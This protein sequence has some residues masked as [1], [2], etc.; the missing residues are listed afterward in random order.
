MGGNVCLCVST[1]TS[2]CMVDWLSDAAAHWVLLLFYECVDVIMRLFV[3]TDSTIVPES[4]KPKV[5]EIELNAL[6]LHN[7]ASLSKMWNIRLLK[8]GIHV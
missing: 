3:G 8:I 4:L 2:G 6:Y 5:I 1:H 7:V